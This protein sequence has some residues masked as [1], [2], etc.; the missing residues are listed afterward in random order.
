[1]QLQTSIASLLAV[2]IHEKELDAMAAITGT[3][4]TVRRLNHFIDGSWIAGEGELFARSAPAHGGLVAEVPCASRAEVDAAVAAARREFEEGAW[5]RMTGFERAAVLNRVAD[6]I[7]A[8]AAELVRLDSEEGGK[9]LRLTEGDI[10]GAATLTRYAA[11]LATQMHGTTFTTNGPDFTGLILREPAG[12]VGLITPWNFPALILCQKLPFALAAGCTVVVKPSEFTSSTTAAIVGFYEEAGLP[13]G[14]LNLTLGT[15]PTGQA[16]TEHMDVD[17]VS[18]TGSTATGRHVIEAGKG[19]LKK[20]SL[21]LGGKAANIVFA[22]ADFEDAVD[23][24]LFGGFFNNGE[25]CVAQSRLLVQDSIAD[26]FLAE[27]ARRTKQLTVGDPLD[28]A[29]DV[30]AL[31]HEGHLNAVLGHVEKGQSQG[32]VLV[33]GGER[34]RTGLLSAGQ[35]IAPTIL[36]R[37]GPE[38]TA[39]G[40]EIFGPVLT[41]TRFTDEHEAIR[42][43]NGVDYGLSNSIWSKNIDKVLVAAKALKSGTVYVNTTIDAPPQ[44]PFGAFKASGVGRE[45]GLAGFEE[46]TELKSINIRTGKRAG[47][48]AFSPKA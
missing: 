47:S 5:P 35:F 23:G 33:T 3:T 16:I 45:M 6:L 25:C 39:F 34:L 13:A 26:D 37:V 21:E 12:V 15:G 41:A 11:G 27:L 43:A 17:V 44:M 24:V 32:A 38:M 30:G 2:L 14:T 46:F 19:N 7:D 28:R 36:D 31:I 9:P 40:H 10:A 42:L 4:S 29:T 20:L 8:N 18:F 22:D 48:F 1:M